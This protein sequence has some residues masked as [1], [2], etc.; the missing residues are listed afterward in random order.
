M[1]AEQLR[2][3]GLGTFPCNFA[4][5]PAIPKGTSWKDW[6]VAPVHAINYPTGIV[7]V[8][9][10]PGVV[11]ID[12]D[13]YKGATRHAVEQAL[14]C[15]LE[16]DNALVQTTLHGGQHYAFRCDWDV[17]FG[18]SLGKVKGLDTRTHG[19]GYIATGDGYTPNGFGVFRL[20]QAAS[21]PVFPEEAKAVLE[22][23]KPEQVER[24]KVEYDSPDVETV[25]SALRYINPGCTRKEW[26]VICAAIR[27]MFYDDADTGLWICNEWSSGALWPKEPPT[28]YEPERVPVDYWSLKPEGETTGGTLFY[29]AMQGGWIPPARF[30][31]S[32]AFGADAL[33]AD[34]YGKMIESITMHGGD[35]HKTSELV[36]E[37]QALQCNQM[38]AGV[39]LSCLKR[40][41][42]D[43]DLL[44]KPVRELLDAAAPSA[45]AKPKT[46]YGKNHT[47][48]AV[49]FL[50]KYY[51]DKTLVRSD[52]VW[53]E[54]IGCGWREVTDKAF[55]H[56]LA[57]DMAGS[58]PQQSDING[59]YAVLCDLM[60]SET[61]SITEPLNGLIL[62]ANGVL[63]THTGALLNH[64][65][66]YFTT[67]MLP[68]NYNPQAQCPTWLRFLNEMLEGDQERIALLQEW[69]G[70]M[71]SSNYDYHKM[72]FMVGPKRSGKGTIG[73]VLERVVGEQNFTGGSLT[74]FAKDSIVA[75]L[76]HKPVM[77]IGDSALTVHPS[78]IHEVIERVKNITGNDAVSFERKYKSALTER[79]PTRITVVA[80]GI[81]RLF[82]DSGAL[83]GRLL[84]LN[85]EVSAYGRE[86]PRLFDVLL[87]EL[88]GIAAWSL[89]GMARLSAQG[90]FTEP[91]SSIQEVELIKENYSPIN[92]FVEEACIIG[93]GGVVST[94][95]LY[96]AYKAWALAR[97]E[98]RILN[99]RPMVTAFRDATRGRKVRY[100][101]KRVDG[102]PG[103]AFE[104]VVLAPIDTSTAGAFTPSVAK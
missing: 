64:S 95:E 2:A 23:V 45:P 101:V 99:P 63:D 103:R 71:L 68:Y 85:F 39:L 100:G 11:V 89:Q 84:V 7:G 3:V 53:Y 59:T 77:F 70:Y 12:L 13:T 97:G 61:S 51:P 72:F 96:S 93:Q 91:A 30:D 21:L 104:N 9:I 22:A 102:K 37:I 35:P 87:T 46:G 92:A 58:F 33:G 76:R 79:L 66:T 28:N 78:K 54:Y 81:P 5:A 18:S 31:T 83:A 26:I 52:E 73:R 69:F 50:E 80:N 24:R 55:R 94:T 88:E 75:E 74:G 14:R 49:H 62:F 90:R 19:K 16:W 67:N 65:P 15:T 17:Q 8:P 36:A 48:N 6:A 27:A 82:D 56:K 57:V 60:H 98:D 47:E 42:K 4:K 86:D 32:V 34:E 29:E 40:E 43:A 44:T 41:L 1:L 38:Q 25:R 20:G 10:P